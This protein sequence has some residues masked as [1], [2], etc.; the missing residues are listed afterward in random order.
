MTIEDEKNVWRMM[1]RRCGYRLE[2]EKIAIDDCVVSMTWKNSGSA[3]CY[4]DLT[5]E[6]D[7]LVDGRPVSSLCCPVLAD[8]EEKY[9]MPHEIPEGA[10]LR[11]RLSAPRGVIS[12]GIR[13]QEADGSY[14]WRL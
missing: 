1:A 6:L 8:G 4:E 7:A 9:R 3:P 14:R 11:L 12:L 5:L 10:E 13:G 2:I